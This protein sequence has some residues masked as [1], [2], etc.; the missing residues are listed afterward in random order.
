LNEQNE[1]VHCADYWCRRQRG[2]GSGI[3]PRKLTFAGTL[4]SV[5]WSVSNTITSGTGITYA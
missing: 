1:D 2:A 4:T 3:H 5:S